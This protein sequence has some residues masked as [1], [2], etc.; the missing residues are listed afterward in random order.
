MSTRNSCRHTIVVRKMSILVA[1]CPKCARVL[2]VEVPPDV[3]EYVRKGIVRYFS[4]Q[5]WS[6][7]YIFSEEARSLLEVHE[8]YVGELEGEEFR[9][10][11]SGV[12]K[13][14]LDKSEE[15]VDKEASGESGV[16]LQVQQRDH[17]KGRKKRK[18]SKD[19][20]EVGGGGGKSG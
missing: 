5:S 1:S 11:E 10:G 17:R 3:P 20:G 12:D 19:K 6:E 18:V 15:V 2:G 7:H 14:S 13:V 9:G 8:K 16:E 4:E